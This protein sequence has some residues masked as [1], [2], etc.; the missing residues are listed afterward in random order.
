M[1]SETERGIEKAGWLMA[2][3]KDNEIA[4]YVR[5]REGGRWKM[6]RNKRGRKKFR[7]MRP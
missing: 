3:W 6:G 4:R 1:R 2:R 5:R 7:W